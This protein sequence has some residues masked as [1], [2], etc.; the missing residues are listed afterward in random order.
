MKKKFCIYSIL[1]LLLTLMPIIPAM[2]FSTEISAP[3]NPGISEIT[4]NSENTENTISSQI[5]ETSEN[6]SALQVYHVLDITTNEILEVPVRE[7]LIGA[8]GA[9]MP[10]SF[11]P[12]ALKAQ[13]VAAHTYAERQVLLAASRSDLQGADFSNDPDQYQAFHTQQQLQ[14]LYGDNFTLYY[15]KISDAVDAVLPEILCYDDEP[16]IAAFHA[17]SAGKTESARN[18][19]GSA[20]TYL[21]SV[22]SSS[23]CNAPSYEQDCSYSAEQIQEML[24]AAHSGLLLGTDTANWFGEPVCS[25][26]GTILQ[27]PVGTSIFTGQELRSVLRLRSACFTISYDK[28]SK[29]F[30]FRTKGYGHSVGMSQYGANAMALQGSNYQEILAHYYPDTVLKTI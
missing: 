4:E 5:S 18:V 16:I 20:I 21:Q 6:S 1:C 23:D 14:K 3:E 13:A 24:S 27:I 2:L 10:A 26:A 8:V 15:Q 19:W 9:E 22:D 30:T 12:E 29:M 25:D 7:Y 17:I 28:K 11:E